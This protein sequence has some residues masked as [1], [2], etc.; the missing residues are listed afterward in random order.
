M[1]QLRLFTQKYR[2]TS[3]SALLV[4]SVGS[5]AFFPAQAQ[6]QV[7]KA[8]IAQALTDSQ[9]Q[10]IR[11]KA[12]QFIQLVSE[13]KA[14]EA[15]EIFY[16]ELKKS[17]TAEQIQALWETELV[18]KLGPFQ[19]VLGSK[20]IDVIN[21][22]VVKVSVQFAKRKEDILIT[23]NK[24]QQLVAVNWLSNKSVED[25]STEFVN[26]L[27]KKDYARARQN[28]SPLLKTEFFAQNIQKNWENLLMRTGPFQKQ[29]S[30]QT[31]PG[32]TT[33]AAN[34]VIVEIQFEKLTDNLFIFFN[35]DKQIVNVDFPE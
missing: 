21:A 35:Q 27:A 23:F 8:E 29:I 25:I 1:N 7:A 16:P 34:V 5:F 30:S 10:G 28:F 9:Q 3:L 24:Q 6:S 26:N 12:E 13:K 4:V 20:A 22:D 14:S 32:G 11:K 33:A 15:R 17:W 19:K 18:A 2:K 31:K